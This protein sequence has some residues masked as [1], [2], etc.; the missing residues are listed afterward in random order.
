[1]TDRQGLPALG[2]AALI[3][4]FYG[5]RQ[6]TAAP[7]L[8]PLVAALAAG[9]DLV[10]AAPE[11]D[12]WQ[13]PAAEREAWLQRFDPPAARDTTA[14]QL[15]LNEPGDVLVA[16]LA[17][18]RRLEAAL[19]GAALE[20]LWGYSL[21]YQAE[22]PGGADPA[23]V[24][25][26]PLLGVARRLGDD[27]DAAAQVLAEAG[28]PA[29]RLWLVDLPLEGEGAQAASVYLAVGPAALSHQFVPQV[30]LGPAAAL[31]MPDLIAHKGYHQARQAKQGEFWRQYGAHIQAMQASSQQLLAL[32]APLEAMAQ[33]LAGLAGAHNRLTVT[34]A[35]L[36]R[37][38]VSLE[39]QLHNLAWW[40]DPS[41]SG[42]LLPYHRSHLE[43][44]AR[45]LE[46]AVSEGR[47]VLDA[48]GAL[49]QTVSARLEASRERK[50]QTLGTLLAVLGVV[51][52]VP[53]L[54][55][56]EAVAAMLAW[57]GLVRTGS[58][59]ATLLLLAVQALLVGLLALAAGWA[60]YRLEGKR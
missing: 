55:D 29:G 49:V 24:D 44:A 50:R 36:G 10:P 32:S 33:S 16:W 31:L 18:R 27:S 47:L 4:T 53:Q 52:A 38:Q 15:A 51:L 46:L 26:A 11:G 17:L 7:R 13:N 35:T 25:L 28:G 59:Q 42:S 34:V 45:E 57:T 22:T 20:G 8:Q 30:L 23:Q 58:P 9:L 41:L 56:R 14:V 40:Q 3:A 54:L 60:V 6:S 37:L 2:S 39:R 5:P 19:A 1:M 48:A 43:S 21:V 12:L